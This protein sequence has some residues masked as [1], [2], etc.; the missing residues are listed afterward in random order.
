FKT[1]PLH[2]VSLK[3]PFSPILPPRPRTS[4]AAFLR[5]LDITPGGAN[6]Q[7]NRRQA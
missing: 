7:S 1:P 6:N 3:G 5:R 2:V 4:E